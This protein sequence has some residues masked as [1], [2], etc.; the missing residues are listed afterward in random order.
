MARWIAF[1]ETGLRIEMVGSDEVWTHGLFDG[2]FHADHGQII[3]I[4]T[5]VRTWRSNG[6]VTARHHVPHGSW[7]W[8]RLHD[9]LKSE[10]SQQ[11]LADFHEHHRERPD[12]PPIRISARVG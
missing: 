12:T 7:L 3:A 11:I 4:A 6:W 9:Q 1:E 2:E 5:T 10:Y 8:R